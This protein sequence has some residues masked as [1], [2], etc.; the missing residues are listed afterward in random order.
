MDYIS[1]YIEYLEMER[2]LSSHTLRVYGNILNEFREYS[3][4]RNFS[5]RAVKRKDIRTFLF[6]LENN[7]PITKRLK[8]TTLRNFFRF[9]E[10]ED[11]IKNN[12]TR[13]LPLPKVDIKEPACLSE[14]EIKK[15]LEA[16]KKDKS[17]FQKRD[18]VAI[19]ILVETGF[20]LS[21]VS[22]ISINDINSKNQTIK[23]NRK[24]GREQ[25][26]PINK[27][28]AVLLQNYIKDKNETSPLIESS[29]KKRM[30]TRRLSIMVQKYL[31]KAGVARNGISVHSLRHSYCV[32]L[33]EKG[34]SLKT[35]QV[36]LGHRSIST[37]ERYMHLTGNQLRREVGLAEVR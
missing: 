32:R 37:T 6:S 28:L 18:A 33:L 30:T 35:T 8:Q 5:I 29:F 22:N 26:V 34:A 12:P 11:I 27:N 7:Q 25:V 17:K 14:I 16:V 15:L 31:E 1:Q 10:D 36:L 3:G 4:R 23:I 2:C 9:L 13:N 24:G 21:E 20:R 19:R